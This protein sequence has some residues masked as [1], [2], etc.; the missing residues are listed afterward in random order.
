MSVINQ[1]SFLRHGAFFG[2][3]DASGKFLNI[4]G[5]GATGS[6]V[7]LLAAKMG[8]HNFKIWDADIVESH[9]LPNQVYNLSHVGQPK[10]TALKEVLE[11]FNPQVNVQTFNHFFDGNDLSHSS[12]LED[13]V[14]VAV[15]SLSARKEIASSLIYHPFVH[16]MFETKMG[17]S[18][19]ILNIIKTDNKEKMTNFVDL[20][21]SDDEVTES[22]CN[23]RIITT[24]TN[25]VSSNVVHALCMHAAED[26]NP[27][28]KSEYYG[29]HIFSLNNSQLTVFK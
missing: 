9:N 28:Q 3:E 1:V 29:Q 15:D 21:K 23:E 5:A 14:F 12:E 13:Y 20:L 19:A 2:P 18:H 16:T 4:I 11:T 24:L 10:V 8:W 22:A 26:R 6:W 17:F 7:A 27:Q 25:I